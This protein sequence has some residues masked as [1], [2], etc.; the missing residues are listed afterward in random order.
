MKSRKVKVNGFEFKLLLILFFILSLLIFPAVSKAQ[1]ETASKE[2]EIEKK[3]AELKKV[4]EDLRRTRVRIQNLYDR[5]RKGTI[6]ADERVMLQQN[7]HKRR[8]LV[9]EKQ[10]LESDLKALHEGKEPSAIEKKLPGKPEG[11]PIGPLPGSTY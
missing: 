8:K 7:M 10:Q 4:N 9:K 6:S 1:S 5:S 11:V 2:A 3:E